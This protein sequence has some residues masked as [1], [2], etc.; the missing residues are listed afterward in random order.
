[1]GDASAAH[2]ALGLGPG[3]EESIHNTS[4]HEP[5][6]P[7]E[8]DPGVVGFDVGTESFD[9]L[10]VSGQVPDGLGVHAGQRAAGGG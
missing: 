7:S 8:A 2:E 5:R 9:T 6:E 10:I 4:A 1:M 3:D